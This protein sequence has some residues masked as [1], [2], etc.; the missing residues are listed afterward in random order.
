MSQPEESN[1]R[2]KLNK[3]DARQ[4]RVVGQGR[5]AKILLT[6][7]AALAVIGILLFLIF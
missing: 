2:T 4:G 7:L 6:S 1:P 3:T 5:V